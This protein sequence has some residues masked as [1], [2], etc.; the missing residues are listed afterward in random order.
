MKASGTLC[1]E[2]FLGPQF[3]VCRKYVSCRF[4]DLPWVPKGRFKQLLI[5]K[6]RGCGEKRGAVRKQ[7]CSL[8]QG[9]GIPSSETHNNIFSCFADTESPAKWK[10]LTIWW[11][12][13]CSREMVT[14]FN[15]LESHRSPS[16]N[17]LMPND[18]W[19]EGTQSQHAPWP[20]SAVPLLDYKTP[21]KPP[22]LGHTVLR[23]SP[24]CGL[25]CLADQQSHINYK[26]A[27]ACQLLIGTCQEHFP[28]TEQQ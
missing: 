1:M 5:R 4:H 24:R 23:V 22:G 9:S 2:A 25:T 7:W 26:L 19:I 13:L 10:M 11:S 8:G 27:L 16:R 18:F 12:I 17:H 20:L 14:Q 28:V 21:H 15:N 6:G 3:L